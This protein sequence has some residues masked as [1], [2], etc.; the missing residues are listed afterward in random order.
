MSV[1]DI[2]SPTTQSDCAR[3]RSMVRASPATLGI[4]VEG[5]GAA[6]AMDGDAATTRD[7]AE[8]VVP[9][10]R[11]AALGVADEDVVDA[12][13]ADAAVVA[14]DDAEVVRATRRAYP[15]IIVSEMR[16]QTIQSS[17]ESL[18]AANSRIRDVDVAQE[19][20]N[21]TSS[22]VLMQAGVSVLSQANQMP[23]LALKLLG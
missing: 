18:S 3:R 16:L 14:L 4:G 12:V 2:F 23:Q 20:A 6:A 13:E 15:A 7:E 9:R 11:I 1:A 21:M 19:T 10:K 8:D 22:Q 5:L 17:S